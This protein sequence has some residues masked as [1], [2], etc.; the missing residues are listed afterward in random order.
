MFDIQFEVRRTLRTIVVMMFAC[1]TK[2]LEIALINS[3]GDKQD[4]I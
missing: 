2:G 4:S 3:T 1:S